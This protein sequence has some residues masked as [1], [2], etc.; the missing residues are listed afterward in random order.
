MEIHSDD[1]NNSNPSTPDTPNNNP[2]H[3]QPL[4]IDRKHCPLGW[5]CDV[6]QSTALGRCNADLAVAI[7]WN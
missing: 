7:G 3:V 2:Q 4:K 5:K 1:T 6:D